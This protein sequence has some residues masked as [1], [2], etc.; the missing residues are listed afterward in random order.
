MI[1]RSKLNEIF[2]INQ[3]KSKKLLSLLNLISFFLQKMN[4]PRRL[5]QPPLERLLRTL[6]SYN[7]ARAVGRLR[8]LAELRG[9]E[10]GIAKSLN[11][12]PA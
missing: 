9:L 6:R 12:D 3:Q 10:L 1:Y 2:S 7:L 11:P 5:A 4:L 8:G